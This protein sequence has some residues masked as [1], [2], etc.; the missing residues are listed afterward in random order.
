MATAA[1][2]L[3]R[4]SLAWD[5]LAAPSRVKSSMFKNGLNVCLD[6]VRT[7]HDGMYTII[8]SEDVQ[9]AVT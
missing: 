2:L 6:G 3:V 9:C 4:S 5:Q 1:S 8:P 7:A